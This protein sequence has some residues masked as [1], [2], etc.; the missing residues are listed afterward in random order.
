MAN[1][2]TVIPAK[3]PDGTEIRI[4]ARHLDDD[5]RPQQV[6]IANLA[7]ADLVPSI[8]GISETVLTA[9]KNVAPSKATVEFGIE[10]SLEAGKLVALLCSGETKANLKISLEWESKAS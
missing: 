1:A 4:E 3:L 10:A 6:G 7:F 9:I 5:G 8:Q 2:S